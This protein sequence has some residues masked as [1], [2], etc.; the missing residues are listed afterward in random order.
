MTARL[1]DPREIWRK[2]TLEAARRRWEDLLDTRGGVR[3]RPEF[4]FC[5]RKWRFD[6]AW[7]EQRIAVEIEGLMTGAGGR[8]QRPAGFAVDCQKYNEAALLGW[9]VLRVTPAQIR[10][11]YALRTLERALRLEWRPLTPTA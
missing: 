7:P 2:A 4:R 5:H 11:G 1:E 8:H 9:L 10:D 3:R 6:R